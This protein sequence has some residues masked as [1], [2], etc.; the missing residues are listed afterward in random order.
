MLGARSLPELRDLSSRLGWFLRGC[1]DERDLDALLDPLG[2]PRRLLGCGVVTESSL[3]LAGAES[4]FGVDPGVPV[5]PSFMLTVTDLG[6][7]LLLEASNF[8][9]NKTCS[10]LVSGFC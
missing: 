6:Q 8:C 1:D 3:L 4:S 9:V 10:K 2:R 7:L 5:F